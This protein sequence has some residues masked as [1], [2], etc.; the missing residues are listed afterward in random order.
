MRWINQPITLATCF[1]LDTARLS[2]LGFNHHRLEEPAI[3]VWNA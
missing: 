3:K 1:L 2:T